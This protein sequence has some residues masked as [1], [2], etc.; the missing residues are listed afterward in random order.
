MTE[1]F[2]LNHIDRT[3]AGTISA[4]IQYCLHQFQLI[5]IAYWIYNR[6]TE[7]N[8][9]KSFIKGAVPGR[10]SRMNIPQDLTKIIVPEKKPYPGSP[11]RERLIQQLNAI[12]YVNDAKNHLEPSPPILSQPPLH[13]E[14]QSPASNLEVAS[15][16]DDV[17]SLVM[18]DESLVNDLKSVLGLAEL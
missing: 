11:D 8:V 12:N 2:T 14:M 10:G 13:E 1:P 9:P 15:R 18:I 4:N 17:D 16:S 6:V 3:R 7:I 5:E